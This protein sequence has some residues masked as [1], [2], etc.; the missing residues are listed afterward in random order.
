MAEPK[1]GSTRGSKT[2]QSTGARIGPS[3]GQ[4]TGPSPA[5]VAAF[6]ESIP[7]ERQRRD[8][9]TVAA[10]L[11]KVTGHAPVMWGTKMVGFGSYHYRYASG[12][13]GDT[14][15]V[16]FAPRGKNLTLYIMDGFTE[17]A[18][19]LERLGK[20]STGKSCLYIKR[21]DDVDVGV[22]EEIVRKSVTAMRDAAAT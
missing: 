3:T 11:E 22:L 14:F 17:Y 13:E 5:E 1:T 8:A 15:L 4:S 2:G 9:S 19:L 12:R 18:A 21:L 20:H 6:L 7:D 16:G 10:L